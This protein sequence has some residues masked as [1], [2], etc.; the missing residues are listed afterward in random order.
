[1]FREAADLAY[2]IRLSEQPHKFDIASRW[3]ELNRDRVLFN[4]D[5]AKS[6]IINVANRQPLRDTDIVE[7][8]LND[9][10][11]KRL[12]IVHPAL[13]RRGGKGRS[14]IIRTKATI[15]TSLNR[16]ISRSEKTKTHAQRKVDPGAR[17]G[18][19]KHRPG[20]LEDSWE[21]RGFGGHYVAGKV[22][23]NGQEK[24]QSWQ[25]ESR[26]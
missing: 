3:S 18:E 7:A 24:C 5:R 26:P 22:T 13:L 8:G 19:K 6:R 17:G 25:K 1:M 21:G 16:P 2:E 20:W 4:K 14:D 23:C 15:L 11:G 12:C 9:R 10:V